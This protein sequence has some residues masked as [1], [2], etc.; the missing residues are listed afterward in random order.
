MRVKHISLNCLLLVLGFGLAY[1]CMIWIEP[2]ALAD[3]AAFVF[4]WVAFFIFRKR[5]FKP[6][7]AATAAGAIVMSMGVFVSDAI[8]EMPID[9]AFLD[10]LLIIVIFVLWLSLI[11]DY[12]ASLF[13]GTFFE[14]HLRSVLNSFAM[15]TWLAGSSVCSMGLILFLREWRMIAILIIMINSCLWLIY[16]GLCIIRYFQLYKMKQT[17][18][19]GVVLLS[20]VSTQS[21]V[22]DY[23]LLLKKSMPEEIYQLLILLGVC[24]YLIGLILIIRQY[25][26]LN[27]HLVS[28]WKNTNCI[29]HGALSITGLASTLSHAVPASLLYFVWLLAFIF[30]IIIE[31]IETFRAVLR[32]KTFGVREAIFVY[33]VSQWARNFTFS[34]FLAFSIHLPKKGI[35]IVWRHFFNH[36]IIVF[37]L[38]MIVLF[39]WETV[40]FFASRLKKPSKNDVRK[41]RMK[42]V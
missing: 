23:S 41:I 36:I 32:I 37:G 1:L 3:F 2:K 25:V 8:Y 39:I 26:R 21:L 31:S 4:L 38:V 28:D 22:I 18:V 27:W 24:F 5:L 11:T 12:T 20:A 9:I 13:K 40:L 42:G 33:D 7:Y 34:M 30:I 35:S 14:R 19:H 6:T 16:A 10:Q 17:L 15:G 29:I